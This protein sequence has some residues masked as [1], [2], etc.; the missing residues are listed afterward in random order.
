MATKSSNPVAQ[1]MEVWNESVIE[2]KEQTVTIKNMAFRI[3]M[4]STKTQKSGIRLPLVGNNELCEKFRSYC[5]DLKNSPGYT[6]REKKYNLIRFPTFWGNDKTELKIFGTIGFYY[7]NDYVIFADEPNDL[8]PS[9]RL[10]VW[11]EYYKKLFNIEVQTDTS[12][13]DL[14]DKLDMSGV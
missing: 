9:K 3:K 4:F 2:E 8:P 14:L 1:T 13:F 10:A 5:D 7:L 6:E 12:L 11:V